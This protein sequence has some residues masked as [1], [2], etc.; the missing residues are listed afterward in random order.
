MDC[1]EGLAHSCRCAAH[2]DPV[3]ATCQRSARRD[4]QARGFAPRSTCPTRGPAT[5]AARGSTGPASSP[6]CS[7]TA[8][9]TSASGSSATTRPCTTPSPDRSR[10]SSPVIRRWAMPRRSRASRSSA[11][12]SAPCGGRTRDP[13]SASIP[14]TSSIPASGRSTNGAGLGSS[15]CT[16]SAT[17]AATPTST[18]RRV[19]VSGDT[20]VLEHS[21]E[22]TPAASAIATSVY[23]HNF[24]T[25][26]GETTGPDFVVR[27][28]FAPRR[29]RPLDGAGRG[30][31]ATSWCSCARSR[32]SRRSSPRSK[33]SAARRATTASGWRTARP[34]PAC[35]S[36]AIGRSRS[37]V[38]VG[39][40]DRL[41]RALHRRQRR[42][43]QDVVVAHH[44]RVLQGR[45]IL[46][47][48]ETHHESS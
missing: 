29:Q 39:V 31:A 46:T 26:D 3:A 37:C 22:A 25:L 43:R 41:P 6:A 36:P 32:R 12:A 19:S 28:P 7:G 44:L 11:S 15:S 10:S 34:A 17:P 8:T 33:A 1:Y 14:T 18:A 42:A 47:F 2:A 45:Q 5:T 20:L 35:A 38:L 16:S 21:L 23:N 4:F 40:E 13:T 27:F 9:S 30:H 24:F 48:T